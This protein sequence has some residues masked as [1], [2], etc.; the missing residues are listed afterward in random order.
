MPFRTAWEGALNVTPPHF[1]LARTPQAGMMA[2]MNSFKLM[3][4]MAFFAM[5][6]FIFF[7][8]C[9]S[10]EPQLIEQREE[11]N[12]NIDGHLKEA[13]KKRINLIEKN[14]RKQ[15]AERIKKDYFQA[16]KNIEYKYEQN[17]ENIKHHLKLCKMEITQKLEVDTAENKYKRLD[18]EEQYQD[19]KIS[20]HEKK[21]KLLL[22]DH[23]LERIKERAK[24]EYAKTELSH[25]KELEKALRETMNFNKALNE[26][27]W[28]NLLK[29]ETVILQKKYDEWK[30]EIEKNRSI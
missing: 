12:K 17:I 29:N 24:I 9:E 7:S 6:T 23:E 11:R 27:N 8:G 14:K 30:N 21:H 10:K 3:Q 18:I 25:S 16:V 2:N 19:G 4:G 5:L 26:K 13:E 28:L 15:Y 22:L 20:R 1:E